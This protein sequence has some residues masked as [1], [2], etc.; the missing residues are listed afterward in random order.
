VHVS[1]YYL[2]ESYWELRDDIQNKSN[3]S[4]VFRRFLD[5]RRFGVFPNTP[6]HV[7][8]RIGGE[9]I[10]EQRLVDGHRRQTVGVIS[11]RS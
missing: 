8:Q 11:V 6:R 7:R 10:A 5:A 1:S 2:T 3:L 4:T 9:K